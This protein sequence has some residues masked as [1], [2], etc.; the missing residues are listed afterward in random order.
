[1]INTT[2][3]SHSFS[4]DICL[5][6]NNAISRLA[7]DTMLMKLKPPSHRNQMLFS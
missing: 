6:I 1:M 7:T 3:I 4:N 5:T 2:I